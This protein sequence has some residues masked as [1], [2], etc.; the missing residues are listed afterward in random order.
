MT[1]DL[2]L[3]LTLD[4]LRGLEYLHTREPQIIHCD[5]KS[6]NVLLTR[7]LNA[8]LADFGLSKIKRTRQRQSIAEQDRVFRY[9]AVFFSR[10]N[11]RRKHSAASDIWAM[12]MV[13]F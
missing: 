1:W 5:L 11:E 7:G 3:R 2:R 8:K 13:M 6:A 9:S 4:I 10:S 12:G